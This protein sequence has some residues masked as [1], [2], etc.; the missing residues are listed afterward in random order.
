MVRWLF[1]TNVKDI[2]TLYFYFIQFLVI[3]GSVFLTFSLYFDITN[4]FLFFS[5]LLQKLGG[6]DSIFTCFV[7][8]KYYSNTKTEKT[9]IFSDNVGKAGVYL[10]THI[11][12]GKIYIGSAVDLSKRFKNYFNKSYLSRFKKMHICNALLH[13]GYP[14]FNLTILEYIDVT[15]LSKY[16]TRKLILEREQ[17][18]LDLIFLVEKS[19]TYNILQVAG[20]LLGYNHT[21]ETKALIGEAK[22]GKSRS[23]ETKAL[24]RKGNLGKI[25]S[26]EIKAKISQT[27]K[28]ISRSEET[29]KKISVAL[30]G[31][32]FSP[33]IRAKLSKA[34]MGK[35]ITVE[36]REKISIIKGTPI[37]VYSKDNLLVNS[38]SSARKAGE[39]Y[40]CAHTTIT[41]Y[42]NS[43]KLFL[44]EWILSSSNS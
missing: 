20:S 39:H 21:E 17:Y 35:T 6:V 40:K 10:W 3:T 31:R 27:L 5:F 13:H 14:S 33:E 41:R 26:A 25:I 4:L 12:S 32:T 36:T 38:F 1:S 8:I 2:G 16:K 7:P 42:L 22:K 43:G 19:D 24:I 15:N 30:K 29:K 34:K 9:Q 18:Y 23:A 28:G 11:K 44:G 37:F